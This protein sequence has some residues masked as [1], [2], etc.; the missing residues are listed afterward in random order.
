M[1]SVPAVEKARY[2][3]VML[4]RHQRHPGIHQC[5]LRI[6]N[7]E[8]R[9]L[10][11]PGLFAYPIERHLSGRHLRLRTELTDRP[12]AL[13]GLSTVIANEGANIFEVVHHRVGSSRS[14][15]VVDLE[16]TLEVRDRAHGDA[17]I[18]ALRAADY[19]AEP[20]QPFRHA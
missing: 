3:S 6:E 1:L 18:Q 16:L 9:S 4:R 19:L 5:L 14:V 8:S 12:G 15:N 11:Y 20:I 17:V 13:V 10:A 2:Y 7:I